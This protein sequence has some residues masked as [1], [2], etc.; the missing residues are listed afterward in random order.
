MEEKVILE[1]EKNIAFLYLNH[2]TGYNSFDLPMMTLF[3]NYLVAASANS[4]VKGVI[5]SGKGKAF[6]TGGDLKWGSSYQG[7]AAVAFHEL[8]SRFHQGI[9]EIRNMR[10]P[11]VAAIN[12]IAAGGGFSLALACDFRMMA[13]S[14]VLKQGYTSNGLTLDGGGT[15]SLVRLVGYAKALE[16]T[17]FDEPIPAAKA[18]EW[19]LVN[20]VV[21]DEELTSRCIKMVDRISSGS[22]TSYGWTKQLLNAAHYN[23]FETQMELERLALTS[24]AAS[25]EGKEGI[26]AFLEKRKPIFHT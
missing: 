25:D 4:K 19:N 5:I 9:L 6:S 14:A 13:K 1:I 3:A 21:E 11:V 12:G 2:P 10:K 20:Q 18:L 23:S 16:I 22:M 24:C 7:G 8:S 17:S 26:N 15:H